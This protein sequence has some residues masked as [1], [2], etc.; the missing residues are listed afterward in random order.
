M[1]KGIPGCGN[2]MCKVTEAESVLVHS[3]QRDQWSWV[4]LEQKELLVRNASLLSSE[5]RKV[6][7]DRTRRV[8]KC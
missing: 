1:E 2:N 4:A 8:D 3:V 5:A 7:Q 6:A